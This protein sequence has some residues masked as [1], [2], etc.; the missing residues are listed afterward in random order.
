MTR[1]HLKL[2]DLKA[3]FSHAYVRAVAHAAG[4]FVQEANR[5]MDGDGVDLTLFARGQN[6]L[7][8]SPRLDVQLK[9]TAAPVAS[10]PFSFPLPVKNYDELRDQ[11]YQVPRILVVLVVP[12]AAADW[13]S[14]TEAELTL[15]HCAYWTSLRGANSTSN[16]TTVTI[17][18]A[19]SAVF[20]VAELTGIM[21][22]ISQ[23]RSP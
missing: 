13:I 20:H 6:G 2:N 22:R 15:R 16:N 3:A 18:I 17:Q 23:G 21:N 1:P 10:D 12:E 5:E 11:N 8:R 4:Y 9:S 14:A 19:R 7:C